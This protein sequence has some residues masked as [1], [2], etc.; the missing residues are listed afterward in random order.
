MQRRLV[1]K[2]I[3]FDQVRFPEIVRVH[4]Y[5][6]SRRGDRRFPSRSRIFPE[7]IAFAL[8]RVS[9]LDVIPGPPRDFIYRVYGTVISTA[10]GDEMTNRSA[11]L[12]EPA[13]YREMVI[14]HYGEAADAAEPTFHEIE[15]QARNLRASYQRGLFPLSDDGVTVNKLLS[16]GGWGPDL[17]PCWDLYLQL[18]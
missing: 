17:D 15:V 13:E 2:L 12:I 4:D 14:R 11:Q 5:L 3:S 6:E 7:D 18:S 16:M 8:G 10:D 9:I 1:D